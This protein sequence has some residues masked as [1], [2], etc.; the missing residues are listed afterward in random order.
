MVVSRSSSSGCEIGVSNSERFPVMMYEAEFYVFGGDEVIGNVLCSHYLSRSDVENSVSSLWIP[1]N[2]TSPV[3]LRVQLKD[4][5]DYYFYNITYKNSTNLIGYSLPQWTSC[6][7]QRQIDLLFAIGN[8]NISVLDYNNTRNNALQFFNY[9]NLSG[10]GVWSGVIDLSDPLRV[11][12]PLDRGTLAHNIQSAVYTLHCSGGLGDDGL[13]SRGT[14]PSSMLNLMEVSSSEFKRGRVH[15]NTAKVLVVFIKEVLSTLDEIHQ[16]NAIAGA[17]NFNVY[18]VT[19]G[20]PAAL[21]RNNNTLPNLHFIVDINADELAYMINEASKNPC[22]QCY[23]FCD[24]SQ[25]IAPDFCPSDTYLLNTHCQMNTTSFP[26]CPGTQINGTC[27][28]RR[29]PQ[30]QCYC[31][32]TPCLQ[33][34]CS[35]SSCIA[36]YR[37]PTIPIPSCHRP[38]CLPNGTWT[39]VSLCP[40][41]E[42]KCKYSACI[43]GD[44]LGT[45][46]D[47][48]LKYCSNSTDR[49]DLS[50]CDPITGAC[51]PNYKTCEPFLNGDKCK[52]LIGSSC[53]PYTGECYYSSISCPRENSTLGCGYCDP[54]TGYCDSA[55]ASCNSS[56]S[57]NISGCINSWCAPDLNYN[58]SGY[59]NSTNCH[60]ASHSCRVLIGCDENEGC[61]YE[62]LPC[63]QPPNCTRYKKDPYHKNCC[64]LESLDCIEGECYFGKCDNSTGQWQYNVSQFPKSDQCSFSI[65]ENGTCSILEEKC[66]SPDSCWLRGGCDP[67]SGCWFKPIDCDDGDPCTVDYCESGTCRNIQ[68]CAQTSL[69]SISRC[70]NG[71]CLDYYKSCNDGIECTIDTCDNTTGNCIHSLDNSRC[72][73]LNDCSIDTCTAEGCL[74][75]PINFSAPPS[76]CYNQYC[77]PQFGAVLVPN[78]VPPENSCSIV[79]CSNTSCQLTELECYVSL[80]TQSPPTPNED[81]IAGTIALIIVAFIAALSLILGL[82]YAG[83][84]AGEWPPHVA[85][86]N[87]YY[88]P[89]RSTVTDSGKNIVGPTPPN[90]L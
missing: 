71:S 12:L 14:T 44:G 81:P 16:M 79:F 3:P 40:V 55:C 50:Y 57:C 80:S 31:P 23:G 67:T 84:Q 83:V 90:R 15:S 66:E 72:N 18:I 5:R 32:E 78:C 49:C 68:S 75:Q 17:N 30:D 21:I 29:E 34:T 19:D 20:Y 38:L 13:C 37:E 87:S 43:D 4:G 60:V 1:Y 11:V 70:Y 85:K 89:K 52:P 51:V 42:D 69:C 7:S 62:E 24:Q 54:L 58:C 35:G 6:K 36:Q 59:I 26:S 65:C 64:L 25:C 27:Y 22:G 73:D 74:F 45:Y 82:C 2:S 56:T 41:L 77:D 33:T 8:W 63:P 88:R 28:N 9:F 10:Y 53:D 47:I 39:S 48:R 76:S 46:C 61:L 86:R